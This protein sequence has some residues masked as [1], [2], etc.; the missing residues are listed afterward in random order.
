[1]VCPC[2]ARYPD[3][4][5]RCGYCGALNA[6]YVPPDPVEQPDPVQ[7]PDPSQ[8][9]YQGQNPYQGYSPGQQP[10]FARE[11]STWHDER[12]ANS[13]ATVSMVCGIIG[14]GFIM[15]ILPI[16]GI[17]AISKGRKAK[18]LGFIGMKATVGIVLGIL[19]VAWAFALLVMLQ[20]GTYQSFINYLLQ[21]AS[22]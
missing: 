20:T 14:M 1:M 8:Q 4:A 16:F 12:A 13:A 3:S 10:F 19:Q 7:T 22:A 2:G 11:D 6:K 9:H 15:P 21:M 5:E 17:I 18:R